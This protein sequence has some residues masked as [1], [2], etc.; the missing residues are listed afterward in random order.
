MSRATAVSFLT[1]AAI[2]E[3]CGDALIRLGI[4]RA[5]FSALALLG[6]GALLLFLYSC[7]VNSPP[8]DF[9]RLLGVYIVFFFVAG[10][11]VSWIVFKQPPRPGV[12]AG[13]VLMLAGGGIMVAWQ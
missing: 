7:S 12:V 3:A 10:Q 6:A 9:G 2:L 1:L 11:I 8:W 13:G 4:R 5:G